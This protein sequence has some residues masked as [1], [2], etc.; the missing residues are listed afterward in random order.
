MEGQGFEEL[1]HQ[2]PFA[3]TPFVVEIFVLLPS[4][5][6]PRSGR[7]LLGAKTGRD[8]ANHNRTGLNRT[9]HSR[10]GYRRTGHSRTR[11]V[12]GHPATAAG[13]P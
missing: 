9:G 2:H 13:P 4:R 7:H 3:G 1:F 11:A 5:P 6:G 8:S 10:T 12:E